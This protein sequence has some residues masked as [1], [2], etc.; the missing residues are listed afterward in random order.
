M[1]FYEYRRIVKKF[2]DQDIAN[3]IEWL[4]QLGVKGWLAVG[5]IYADRYGD[6]GVEYGGLFVREK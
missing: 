6:G 5:K 4:N 3:E 2:K 1:I